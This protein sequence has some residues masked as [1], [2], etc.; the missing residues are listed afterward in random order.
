MD[1]GTIVG[2]FSC[3]LVVSCFMIF[4]GVMDTEV[5]FH[6]PSLAI[7]LGGTCA[8]LLVSVPMAH[9]QSLV[10]IISKGLS[11]KR[12]DVQTFIE[13]MRE[14]H[15]LVR[16]Q[17]F[18]S[19]YD[20]PICE[21]MFFKHAL[22]EVLAQNSKEEIREVLRL[23]I[24]HLKKRHHEAIDMIRRIGT[25]SIAFGCTG[26]LIGLIQLF[27][28]IQSVPQPFSI[29]TVLM[30]LVY[31]LLIAHVFAFPIA[32]KLE[33]KSKMEIC[34]KELISRGIYSLLNRDSVQ[35]LTHHL[36]ARVPHHQQFRIHHF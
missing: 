19:L 12:P 26:A 2:F 35:L 14:I 31:G 16:S 25:Y 3:V 27:Q 20:E 30:S 11:Y 29:L 17:G 6:I 5:L 15:V 18:E 32:Q 21:D 13:D 34:H 23:E 22:Q 36:N 33:F 1:V 7:V 24:E 4:N 28:N 8:A 9:I 10:S